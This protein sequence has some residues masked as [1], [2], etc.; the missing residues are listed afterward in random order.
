M[1]QTGSGIFVFLVLYI[2]NTVLIL[3]ENHVSAKLRLFNATVSYL[4]KVISDK[5]PLIFLLFKK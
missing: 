3:L 2:Y 1:Y 5:L 4:C